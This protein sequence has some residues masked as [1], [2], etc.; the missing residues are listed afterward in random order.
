MDVHASSWEAC[1]LGDINL[2]CQY[3]DEV[4]KIMSLN[5]ST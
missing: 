4:L 3:I 1:E 2:L 5:K